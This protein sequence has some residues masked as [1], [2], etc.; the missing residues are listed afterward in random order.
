LV[1]KRI[2]TISYKFK[3]TPRVKLHSTFGIISQ[4]TWQKSDI[5]IVSLH[6]PFCMSN[7]TLGSLFP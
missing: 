1:R 7:C 5:S 2:K 6:S 4:V 3:I